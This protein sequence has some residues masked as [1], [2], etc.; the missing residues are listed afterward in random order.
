MPRIERDKSLQERLIQV[1]Q[2]AG[3]PSAAAARLGLSRTLV[4]RF[5]NSGCAIQRS[6]LKIE[7]ALDAW[8]SQVSKPTRSEMKNE[9][10]AS[11]LQLEKLS[12]EEFRTMRKY[13]QSMVA[14]MDL[15]E[16]N[17]FP[18]FSG[19]RSVSSAGNAK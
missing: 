14:M 11:F 18:N 7:V 10:N 5:Y 17:G 16:E 4:W 3:N 15:F 1:V 6:R 12:P 19:G 8:S 2:E 9:A 13:F